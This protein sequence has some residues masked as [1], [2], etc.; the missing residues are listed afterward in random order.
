[1]MNT[2]H[3]LPIFCLCLAA[4]LVPLAA[5]AQEGGGI[6]GA[7]F[8][9]VVPAARASAMGGVFDPLG[10]GLEAS[11]FN[12]SGLAPLDGMRLEVTIDPLP[13]EV[14]NARLGFGFPL[15]GGYAA[16]NAQLLNVGGF[17]FVN[18][19]GQPEASVNVFD[20]AAGF[21]YSRYLWKS[22]A[23]GADVKAVYRTL[24]PESTENAFAVA[25]NAGATA[26]FETPHI[27][28]RPKAPTAAQLENEFTKAKADIEKEKEK[29]T[30]SAAKGSTEARKK[31]EAAEKT[32]ADVTAQ[33]E[34][35]AE[36]KK[37]AITAKKQAAEADRDAAA[38]AL[39]EAEKNDAAVL[40]EI[41]AW[42][43][44][45]M[46]KAEAAYQ[47]KVANLEWIAS[48]RKRLFEVI[49][50]PTKDLTPEILNTN[51]DGS[52]QKTKAFQEERVAAITA[53]TAAW[54]QRRRIRIEDMKKTIAGYEALIDD[55]VGPRRAELVKA[56][57][58]LK[59]E[60]ATLQQDK[61]AN[62]DRLSVLSKEIDAKQKEIDGL[63]SD[64]WVKRL[65]ERIAGKQ[66]EVAQVEADIAAGAK[67]TEEEIAAE[68]IAA[69][70]D[71]KAFEDLRASLQKELKKAKLKRELGVLEARNE[72]GVA[73]AQADYKVS[74]KA[75]YTQLLDA[76]YEHEDKI[77]DA[78]LEAVT[79][80]A[81]MRRFDFDAD[82]LKAAEAADDEWAFQDRVLSAKIAELSAGLAKGAEEP[83][84]LKTLKAERAA[85]ETAWRNA[86]AG[87]IAK[88]REFDTTEKARVDSATTEIEVERWKTQ[89]VYLQT[90]KPYL[91]TAVALGVRNVGS[92][93]KFVSETVQMPMSATV[94]A[95]YAL[96]NVKDHN[97][98]I[99]LQGDLPLLD[100][101][102]WSAGVGLEY[103]FAGIAY[104]RVGYNASMLEFGLQA[105]SGGLG[106]HLTAGFT[107][108]AVDYAFKPLPDYGFQH[109]IGITVGF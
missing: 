97:L 13:N 12:P 58:A 95:S 101:W 80:E 79:T 45:E 34:A 83:E 3:T 70:K 21:A 47:K 38:A 109:S 7:D 107:E 61:D 78:R 22:I 50:D 63:S 74:E 96:L 65:Q 24:G 81:E 30:G 94:N 86:Q 73:K 14:L 56:L 28:Q 11:F 69:E 91:N 10:L 66:K 72:K 104:V 53:R 29:R 5:S 82:Q 40:A 17:T 44:A 84:E 46:G 16:A 20:A 48:E 1:M 15:L 39:A 42:Y 57:E 100:L 102:S 33:L 54:E 2:K 75:L 36:D 99:A 55:A 6:S 25:G 106:V 68:A 37:E 32:V 88:Q 26:W 51:I 93:V 52:I 60:Q 59:A 67:A 90:D 108:Y 98:K 43:K 18:E 49:D 87:V 105:L 89:L 27:G 71:V 103:V 62:K 4:L 35:A 9:T 41:D 92:P 23:F 77:L 31:F 19:F 76:M 85:K 8:L 64:P